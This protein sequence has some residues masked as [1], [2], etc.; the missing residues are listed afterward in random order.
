MLNDFI[1]SG[2]K[3]VL[4]RGKAAFSS[5]IKPEKTPSKK[6]AFFVQ[7]ALDKYDEYIRERACERSRA[8]TR[9]KAEKRNIRP[10]VSA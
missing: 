1:L 7:R 2:G 5:E 8:A 9:R 10:R 3:A 4:W 6:A